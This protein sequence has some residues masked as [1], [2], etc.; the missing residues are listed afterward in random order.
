MMRRKDKPLVPHL[1][2]VDIREEPGSFC[3]ADVMAAK[4]PTSDNNALCE[5]CENGVLKWPPLTI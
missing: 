3:L 5:S 1:D 2:V 4:A